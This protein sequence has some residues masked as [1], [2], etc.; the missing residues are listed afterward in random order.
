MVHVQGEMESLY[1][2]HISTLQITISED[3]PATCDVRK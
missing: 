1:V 3:L 2:G